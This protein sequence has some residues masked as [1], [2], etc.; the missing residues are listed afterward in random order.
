MSLRVYDDMSVDVEGDSLLRPDPLLGYSARPHAS[1]RRIERPANL[2]YTVFSDGRGARVDAAGNESA[3]TDDIM[4]VGG[5]FA[6]G[7]GVDSE[8]T[9][10]QRLA[11]TLDSSVSNLA[12]GSYGTVQALQLLQRHTDARPRAVVYAFITA[13]LGRNVSPCAPSVSPFCLPVAHM[14]THAHG[15]LHLHPPLYTHDS[16]RDRKFIEEVVNA[17]G[18][19]VAHFRWSLALAHERMIRRLNRKPSPEPGPSLAFLIKDMHARVESMGA[20]LIVV[21]IPGLER[22]N[23]PPPPP[24]LTRAVAESTIFLD[25]APVVRAYYA[26]GTSRP[27]LRFER[28][29]HPNIHGHA[30]IARELGPALSDIL[31]RNSL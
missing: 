30:L 12:L 6:W 25:L 11:T 21:Y 7:H 15:E 29:G 13:H 27:L 22:S 17:P 14:C 31:G 2:D 19:N 10:A 24:E 4:V 20:K 3:S 28:D 9:F 5:S 26:E 23:T 8:H 16:E 18:F 1:Q